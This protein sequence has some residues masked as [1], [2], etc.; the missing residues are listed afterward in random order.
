MDRLLHAFG[1]SAHDR[2]LSWSKPLSGAQKGAWMATINPKNK[3]L[4]HLIEDIYKI[5]LLPGERLDVMMKNVISS[6]DSYL[7][8]PRLHGPYVLEDTSTCRKV[9]IKTLCACLIT[10]A[11]TRAM[12]GGL[13]FEYEPNLIHH[14]GIFNDYSWACVFNLPKVFT[15]KL[16]QAKHVLSSAIRRY[17]RTPKRFRSQEAW[18]V[19]AIIEAAECF[20]IDEDSQVAM[21]LMVWW[22]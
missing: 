12:F 16:N 9:S 19:S 21:L 17:L 15:P 13:I 8:W 22:A 1:L 5:Q 2:K 18:S 4:V 10:E 7:T 14:L 11:T 20:G 3:D 6:L